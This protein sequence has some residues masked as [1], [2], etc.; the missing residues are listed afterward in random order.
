MNI[1][2]VSEETLPLTHSFSE[3]VY[4]REIF[5]PKG[6]VVV[7][8]EHK[9]T[10]L[11]IV[12]V[13]SAYVWMNGEKTFIKAPY[14]FESKAG[15]RKVLYILEDM[16][17]TTIHKTEERDLDKLTELCVDVEKSDKETMMNLLERT[18]QELL[19]MNKQGEL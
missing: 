17:W 16:F 8:H 10:H 6:M 3:G 15:V 18:N 2:Q 13:G 14:T 11:N 4:A 12:S 5:M 7:G 1:T 9:T 19:L